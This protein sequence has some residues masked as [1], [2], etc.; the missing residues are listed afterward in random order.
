MARWVCVPGV[1]VCCLA[2]WVRR[3]SVGL[4]SPRACP[5][6]PCPLGVPVPRG[7][8]GSVGWGGVVLS[9]VL[10]PLLS[11]P[12]AS[13]W[14]PVFGVAALSSSPSGAR[15]VASVWWPLLW[16][17]SSP[18]GEG[19]VLGCAVFSAVPCVGVSPSPLCGCTLL[20]LCGARWSVGVTW[21]G[22]CGVHSRLR[23]CVLA[24][25]RL[26]GGPPGAWVWPCS[27]GI[28]Q[29]RPGGGAGAVPVPPVW[30]AP[31]SWCASWCPSLPPLPQCHGPWPFLY[32]VLVVLRWSLAPLLCCPRCPVP[33][34]ACLLPWASPRPLAAGLLF[35]LSFSR[36]LLVGWW[37]GL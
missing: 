28:A 23:R 37:R 11:C 2:W 31:P 17:G 1:C 15:A 13:L 9:A 10:G 27:L 4:P 8:P 3:V 33:V 35:A 22:S 16:P 12:S 20:P 6:V 21:C 29:C 32:P 18:G 30:C 19:A 7:V 5:L 14:S 26:R 24:G 36:V 34:G 25:L